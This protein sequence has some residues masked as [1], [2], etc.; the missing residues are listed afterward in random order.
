MSETLI[1]RLQAFQESLPFRA[2][3]LPDEP[4][5]LLCEALQTL[6]EQAEAITVLQQRSIALENLLADVN[7]V[8]D[9]GLY[10]LLQNSIDAALFMAAANS[11]ARKKAAV[12]LRPYEAKYE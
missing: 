1:A 11:L 5:R 9:L 10:P 3:T 7:A 8:A 2:W 4:K 12:S 6:A